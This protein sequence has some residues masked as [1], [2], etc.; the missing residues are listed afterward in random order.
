MVSATGSQT[1]DPAPFYADPPHQPDVHT[2][3]QD[4]LLRLKTPA[5]MYK[6]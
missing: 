2:L 6:K 5:L 1:K 4:F 3:I